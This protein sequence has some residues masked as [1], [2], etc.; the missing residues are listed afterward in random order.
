MEVMKDEY[1]LQLREQ[2]SALMNPARQKILSA[3][4]RPKTTAQVAREL[5]QPRNRIGH[6]VRRLQKLGLLVEVERRG[7]SVS[8]QRVAQN[9]RVPFSLTPYS[10]PEEAWQ[11]ALGDLGSLLKKAASDWSSQ[12]DSDFFVMGEDLQPRVPSPVRL[13]QVQLDQEDI[14]ALEHAV[15]LILGK[16]SKA[17]SKPF[18]FGL[19]LLPAE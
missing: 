18:I 17:S 6:H 19:L 4:D 13:W 12:P 11:A 9:L 7:R 3:F 5:R 14:E 16:K 15:N 1:L 10:E 8:L 2:A